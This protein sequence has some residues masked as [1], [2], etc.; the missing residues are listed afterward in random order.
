MQDQPTE[1][2]P[3]SVDSRLNSTG[4]Q[5]RY[6]AGQT[7]W[8]RGEP[9]PALM[10]WVEGGQLQPNRILVPGCGRGYEV[11]EL[12]SRGFDVTAI[13]FAD[14]PVQEL[15][16]KLK[17]ANLVANVL[18]EDI[19]H[20]EPSNQF[21]A[22]YEQTCLCAINPK[23]WP[24]YEQR[25]ANNLRDGGQLFAL[26]MQTGKPDGPP[27]TCGITAMRELFDES[28]WVWPNKES[29]VDHPAGLQEIAI[30]LQRKGLA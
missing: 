19:L 11:I 23:H 25:L 20:F 30:I 28:R 9:S 2:S 27:F 4:W 12:A 8:D 26:F 14:A 5:S 15:T 22:I 21:D 16:R 18:Q 29:A 17:A 10:Q 6:E 1:E 7:G 24:D 13:D 3:G